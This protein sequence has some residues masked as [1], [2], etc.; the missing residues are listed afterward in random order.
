MR[1]YGQERVK[2][3]FVGATATSN[4]L[5]QAVKSDICKLKAS[6]LRRMTK[7]VS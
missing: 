2:V 5:L 1:E 4:R 3:W 6:N 7:V